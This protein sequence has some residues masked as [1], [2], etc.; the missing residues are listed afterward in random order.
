MPAR[1]R[2]NGR[3]AVSRKSKK[4]RNVPALNRLTDTGKTGEI[5][6]FVSARFVRRNGSGLR[7][8]WTRTV[9]WILHM[10]RGENGTSARAPTGA[11]FRKK[12]KLRPAA[13]P[14]HPSWP[15]LARPTR[16][17]LLA[18]LAQTDCLTSL[19]RSLVTRFVDYRFLVGYCEQ[20]KCLTE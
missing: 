1:D 8:H 15:R 4:A 7:V 16:L 5:T 19:S 6:L 18:R 9:L 2:L 13:Q 14:T 17:A 3:W 10:I 20:L 12:R 11:T